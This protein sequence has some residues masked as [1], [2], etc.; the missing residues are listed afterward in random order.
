MR[1]SKMLPFAAASLL[2]AVAV[3]AATSGVPVARASAAQID[4]LGFRPGEELRYVLGPTEEL[5]P[6]EGATWTMRLVEVREEPGEAAIGVFELAFERHAPTSRGSGHSSSMS[7][8]SAGRAWVNAYG[9]PLNVR[10]DAEIQT[11]GG[12]TNFGVSYEF[13]GESFD[14]RVAVDGEDRDRTVRIPNHDGLDRDVPVGLYLFMPPGSDCVGVNTTSSGM[15]GGN[16]QGRDALFGNPGLFSMVMPA[17][18]EGGTGEGEFLVFM[19]TRSGVVRASR[20]AGSNVRG[21][22]GRRRNDVAER[23]RSSNFFEQFSVKFE[24]QEMVSLQLGPRSVDAWR[25][26]ADWP[27]DAIYVDGQGRVVRLDLGRTPN[28]QR[29]LHIRLLSRTEY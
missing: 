5:F 29:D 21:A 3:S 2:A 22:G 12:Q 11:S 9:F 19:P 15:T 20:S 1:R 13:D 7:W 6:G 27:L 8:K 25:L 18:W 28:N 16:C 10:F 14:A 26:E 17:L 4:F 24:Q 23:N